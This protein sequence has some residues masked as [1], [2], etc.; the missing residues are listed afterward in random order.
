M[1]IGSRVRLNQKGSDHLKAFFG[2]VTG[3]NDPWLVI[4]ET[5]STVSTKP[6]PV[7]P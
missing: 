1:K 7:D 5:F 6:W 4:A 3:I 2:I